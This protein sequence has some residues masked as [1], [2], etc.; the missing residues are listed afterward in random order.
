MTYN[1]NY[2]KRQMTACSVITTATIG[3]QSFT[4]VIINSNYVLF[5]MYNKT[6]EKKRKRFSI[7]NLI[8]NFI[9]SISYRNGK[10]LA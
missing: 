3:N 2:Y 4:D 8:S 5:Y 10:R 9:Q 1:Y 6:K 7:D